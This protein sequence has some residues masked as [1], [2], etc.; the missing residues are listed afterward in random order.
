MKEEEAADESQI[1]EDVQPKRSVRKRQPK[2]EQTDEDEAENE[3]EILEEAQHSEAPRK[4]RLYVD[5]AKVQ[6]ARELIE[7]KLSNKEMSLLLELS[8]A[9]VRKL[10]LKILNGTVDELIDN[11]EDHYNKLGRGRIDGPPCPR[12]DPEGYFAQL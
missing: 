12:S 2:I 11:S 3:E 5:R 6:Y 9:C 4:R 7:N 1:K 8:I 10:K